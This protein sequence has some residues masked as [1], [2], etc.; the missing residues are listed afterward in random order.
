[1]IDPQTIL[2]LVSGG[3]GALVQLKKQADHDKHMLMMAALKLQN[4]TANDAS[5]RGSSWGRRFALMIIIGV[6]F[7]GLV[8]AASQGIKVSQIVDKKPIID[9]L[10]LIKIG[11]GQRVVEAAVYRVGVEGRDV[12][13]GDSGHREP[14]DAVTVDHCSAAVANEVERRREDRVARSVI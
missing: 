2:G 10:G 7:G 5:K 6:A 3:V 12:V 8:Y 1:M 14:F 13:D 9:F 11:G 4:M